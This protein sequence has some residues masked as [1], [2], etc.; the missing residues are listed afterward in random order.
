[1]LVTDDGPVDD[2]HATNHQF[3]SRHRYRLMCALV[4]AGLTECLGNPFAVFGSPDKDLVV[5]TVLKFSIPGAIRGV[6][7]KSLWCWSIVLSCSMLFGII[8]LL[9][10]TAARHGCKLLH[11]CTKRSA[12]GSSERQALD[13]KI[14]GYCHLGAHRLAN[15][16]FSRDHPHG[17]ELGSICVLV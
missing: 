5:I 4:A 3:I 15:R 7:A 6:I 9:F 16:G 12:G 8:G 1:M 13:P 11:S 17:P 2:D 14:H 10:A